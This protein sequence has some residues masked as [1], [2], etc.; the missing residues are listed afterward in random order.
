MN[1]KYLQDRLFSSLWVPVLVVLITAAIVAGI[2]LLAIATGI[3]S[4]E[5]VPGRMER[6]DLGQPFDLFV[7]YAHTDDALR[8]SISCLK[9]ITSGRV[10]CVFGAGGDRDRA[11]RPRLG[12]AA[13]DARG[14]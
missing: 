14:S 2:P 3:E 5:C 12:R 10:I 6:I 4:L 1:R 11:K 7:D 9:Q 8:R 13:A